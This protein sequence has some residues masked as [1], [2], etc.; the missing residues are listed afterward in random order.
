MS[1]LFYRKE[2]ANRNNFLMSDCGGRISRIVCNVNSARR[3]TL[4]NYQLVGNIV[5][6]FAQQAEVIIST[7]DRSAFAIVSNPWPQKVRFCELSPD[8]DITI[9]PQD[10]FVVMQKG[11]GDAFLL[12]SKQFE[13]AKDRQMAAELAVFLNW[14][15]RESKLSFEGGNIVS[16]EQ[17][18]F[19]GAN[20]ILQNAAELKTTQNKIVRLFQREFGRR[21]IVIGSAR[22]AVGHIDMM[23]T[24]MGGSRIAAADS[25]WG[26]DIAEQELK[27]NP[28]RVS[29]FEDY[30]RRNFFGHPE[31]KVL[32]DAN[33]GKVLPPDM[34]GRTKLAVVVSRKIAGELDGIADGLRKLGY[35]VIRLPFLAEENGSQAAD[36]VNSAGIKREKIGFPY[37]TYNNVL[38]ENISGEK[39]VYLPQYGWET[40][41]SLAVKCWQ[42]AGFIVRPVSGFATSSMYGGSLRCCVKVLNRE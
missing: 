20:T 2:A 11:N 22:Q 40:F 8:T 4:R 18:V 38:I 35:E 39:I 14:P 29:E 23:L 7:N 9:W 36:D 37:L 28:Q 5:N 1:F 42:D 12:L 17:N 41:D 15:Y 34:T 30:C 31:I 25:D 10:P 27:H 32:Y 6:T 24:P 26:A 13:R 3:T 19:I 33:G 16:D 21:V